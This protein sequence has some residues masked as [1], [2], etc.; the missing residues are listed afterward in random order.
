MQVCLFRNRVGIPCQVKK[1]IGTAETITGIYVISKFP[2]WLFLSAL[3][4]FAVG[5]SVLI[6]LEIKKWKG[7]THDR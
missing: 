4:L 5:F 2:T 1:I 3:S 6:G 7:K